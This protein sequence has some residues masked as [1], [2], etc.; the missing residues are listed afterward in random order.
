MEI[1]N[2]LI[3]HYLKNVLFINGTAYAGKS[4]MAKMLAEA[5]GLIHCGEN[6]GCVPEGITSPET[7][8]NLCY[9]QTM[10][11]WQEFIHRTPEEYNSWTQGCTRE[12]IEFEIMYLM[13]ISQLQK[14]VVDTNL[15]LE[16]LREI[17]DYNQVAVM[18]SPKTMSVGHFFD[19]D[20]PDKVFLKEQ[21]MRA[22]DPEKAMKNFLACMEYNNSQDNYNGWANSGFF[23]IVRKDAVTDTRAETL[24]AL[25]KHFGLTE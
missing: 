22:D 9:F 12:L 10:R 7:H 20:D 13:R 23:T 1:S 17:A 6:Y 14:V 8:P 24:A 16:I 11:D 19:R 15:P 18:L 4:T 21:I 3:K 5:Y 25:A 2:R